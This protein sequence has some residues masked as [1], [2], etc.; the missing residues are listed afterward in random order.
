[1][2][3]GKK[4]ERFLLT[5]GDIVCFVFAV[6]LTLALRYFESPPSELLFT[7]LWAFAPAIF[8]WLIVF[9]IYNL[10]GKQTIVFRRKIF[11]TIINAQLVN[12]LLAV[13]LFYFAPYFGLTPKT[14]LFIYFVFSTILIVAWRLVLSPLIYVSRP[15]ALILIGESEEAESIARELTNNSYYGYRL[16]RY[17]GELKSESLAKLVDD[18][19]A[20]VVVTHFRHNEEKNL[21][22]SLGV[23]NY[24]RLKVI[25]ADVFYEEMF[26]RIPL[27]RVNDWW[28]IENITVGNSRRYDILKR[29]MDI[30]IA[31][32]IGLA[33][34]P[35]YPL[36]A[37][38]IWVTDRGKIFIRQDRVGQ[39]GKV[40]SIHKFR[41]MTGDDKGSQV[42]K[43]NLQVTRVGAFLRATRIDE[44]P[45]LWNVLS[46]SLSLVGP[47]P[48][49]PAL[50]SKYE[51]EIPFY[52]VRHF[53]K[54]GLSGWA[55]IY[56]EGHPHHAAAVEDTKDKL[57]Y[58]LFYLKHRSFSLDVKIAFRTLQIILSCVGV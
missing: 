21:I 58:D 5:I 10:Y 9:Y 4:K 34:L 22:V 33:T 35:L 49:F 26:D 23:N 3:I 8:F 15:D 18:E 1:M 47:R 29:A 42:L 37:F 17:R 44:L 48:E 25:D 55:Q 52:G 12:G 51:E 32:L 31:T 11:S 16:I 19:H 24:L 7:H 53:I 36:V 14:N 6:W 38:A 39:Y 13:L 28:F 41:T 50:V 56:H 40:F 30:F 57:S 27:S 54:P 45:Q 2:I 20:Q 43:S 46:G